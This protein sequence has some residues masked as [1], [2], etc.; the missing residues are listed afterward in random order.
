MQSSFSPH[1]NTHKVYC[2]RNGQS[3]KKKLGRVGWFRGWGQKS[4]PTP[5]IYPSLPPDTLPPLALQSSV[6][7]LELMVT[8]GIAACIGAFMTD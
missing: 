7:C 5:S 8:Q 6:T 3:L 1:Y 4:K 2:Y